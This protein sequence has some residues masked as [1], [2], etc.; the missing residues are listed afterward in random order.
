MHRVVHFEICA[1]EPERAVQFYRNVFG[2]EIR[3]WDGPSEYSIVTTGDDGTPGINGGLVHRGGSVT[4]QGI[5]FI[6][7]PSLDAALMHIADNGGDMIHPRASV[8]GV[9]H[10]AYCRDTEGNSFAIIETDS[11]AT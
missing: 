5:N 8:P 7:V 4:G 3:T 9:G 2:W 6:D 11:S 10:V 1:D